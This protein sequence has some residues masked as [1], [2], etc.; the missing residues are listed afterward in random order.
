MIAI[1]AP[2][3]GS[4]AVGMLTR[5]LHSPE[6]A[7]R[8][9]A[10]S[11]AADCDLVHLGTR[12]SAAEIERTENTQPLLVATG[13]LA[14]GSLAGDLPDGAAAVAGHSVGELTAAV[15]AGVLS[16]V[17]AVRLAAVRGRAMA[18]ACDAAPTSMAAVVGGDE[19]A[20]LERIAELGLDPAT[21]NGPG[22]IV[23]AGLADDL[24]RLAAA[25]PPGATVKFLSV[26]GAFHTRYMAGAQV[27]FAAA[28]AATDFRA[29]RQVLLSNADGAAVGSG[30]DARERLVGQLVRPVRWDR[31]LD[32][33]RAAAPE[34]AV[35]LPPARTLSTIL[36]RQ[37]PQLRVLPV[38]TDRDLA[39][40]RDQ[41][42]PVRPV[43]STGG[44]D[45]AAA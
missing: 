27:A 16:D 14:L 22:Q 8:V 21:F 9:R 32:A 13:L 2:G 6:R 40:V 10:W 1:V 37:L 26:A 31:C 39:A 45:R 3:Q 42:A 28:A 24:R 35:A 33:V 15:L 20:V 36:K 43:T 12:A 11:A 29:P 44:P 5:G 18:A 17:D 30:A 7:E 19:A 38:A 34:V 4:Q 23:A 25:P 41:I